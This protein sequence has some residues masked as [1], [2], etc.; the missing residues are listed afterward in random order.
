M[1]ALSIFLDYRSGIDFPP[2]STRKK[3]DKE[4]KIKIVQEQIQSNTESSK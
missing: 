4:R 1:A 3:V 2:S